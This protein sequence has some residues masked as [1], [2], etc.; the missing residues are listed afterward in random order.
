LARLDACLL[1]WI[2]GMV[3]LG[4]AAGCGSLRPQPVPTPHL[5]VAGVGTRP[6]TTVAAPVPVSGRSQTYSR[7]KD[8]GLAVVLVR[9]GELWL[10]ADVTG[11]GEVDTRQFRLTLSVDRAALA[12]AGLDRYLCRGWIGCEQGLPPDSEVDVVERIRMGSVQRETTLLSGTAQTGR[13]FLELIPLAERI[14]GL[15]AAEGGMM[16]IAWG[17]RLRFKRDSDRLLRLSLCPTFMTPEEWAAEVAARNRIA[18]LAAVGDG[19]ALFA[20]LYLNSASDY[21][22]SHLP[23]SQRP[24]CFLQAAE[25]RAWY[26]AVLQQYPTI[27][28]SVWMTGLRRAPAWQSSN[29]IY[30]AHASAADYLADGSGVV[31]DTW[32]PDGGTETKVQTVKEFSWRLNRVRLEETVPV[33]VKTH[34][35]QLEERRYEDITPHDTHGHLYPPAGLLSRSRPQPL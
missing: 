14:V 3:V 30:P 35:G 12:A 26:R 19:G 20:Q 33:M 28:E 34:I 25:V 27:G 16:T 24:H 23:L 1:R 29:M 8:D 15:D 18:S 22:R 9:D 2:S 21:V 11:G 13:R 6:P 17:V 31:I 4:L 7:F 10:H 32:R 5:V